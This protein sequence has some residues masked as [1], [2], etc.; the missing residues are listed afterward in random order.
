MRNRFLYPLLVLLA[1]PLAAPGQGPRYLHLDFNENLEAML[2]Q[3]L[4]QAAELEWMLNA[5]KKLPPDLL[6]SSGIDLNSLQWKADRSGITSSDPKLADK[7][8]ELLKKLPVKLSAE[9]RKAAQE[10]ANKIRSKTSLPE[11]VELKSE[12]KSPPPRK[13][14]PAPQPG[15]KDEE[16]NRAAQKVMKDLERSPLGEVLRNSRAWQRGFEELQR[17]STTNGK[18]M[19]LSFLERWTG[20][21]SWPEGMKLEI[22]DS[23]LS[24]LR[25]LA[26]PSLP[27]MNVRLP[28]VGGFNPSLNL[29]SFGGPGAVPWEGVLVVGVLLAAAAL[30]WQLLVRPPKAGSKA[31]GVRRLGPWPVSPGSVSNP[32]EFIQAFEYLALLR[33]GWPARNWHHRRIA[34]GLAEQADASAARRLMT[35]YEEVRYAPAASW[36]NATLV[37]ARR[38]LCLVA[39]VPAA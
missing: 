35:L 10:A 19:D 3:H 8:E 20:R 23:L 33:L 22:S 34:D 25:N 28:K 27:R 36:S 21:L 30:L 31:N 7:L 26:A 12:P 6:K 37:S 9:D 32:A 5:L 17:G 39:G 16:L 11:N 29:P 24:K 2:K 18:G 13:P 4:G 1:F 15:K 14:P 38:D